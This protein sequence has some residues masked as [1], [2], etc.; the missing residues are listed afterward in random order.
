MKKKEYSMHPAITFALLIFAAC[1]F[2]YGIIAWMAHSGTNFWLI[3]EAAGV[4][5][6]ALAAGVHFGILQRLPHWLQVTGIVMI[7]A[8]LLVVTILSALI[9]KEFDDVGDDNLDYV[10]VLGAQLR[11][12]GPSIILKDRL[13]TAVTYLEAHPGTKCIVSGGQGYNEPTSEAEGMRDYLVEHGIDADRILLEDQSTNTVENIQFSKK[14]LDADSNDSYEHVGILTNNFHVYR[15]IGIAKKQGLHG[16]S[17][18][19]A[20]CHPLYI[21]NNVLREV[22][23]VLKDKAVGNM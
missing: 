21:P 10:I 16:V 11:N 6:L 9:A 3:W 15:A 18:I 22:L 4:F 5:F 17:G 14:I 8:G 19:A 13:D 23:G 7:A 2:V 1:G 12:N 20:P